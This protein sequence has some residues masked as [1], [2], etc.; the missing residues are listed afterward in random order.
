MNP[1]PQV[2]T[3]PPDERVVSD[4]VSEVYG[5]RGGQQ[6]WG[7]VLVSSSPWDL[8]SYKGVLVSPNVTMALAAG[9][10]AVVF[11]ARAAPVDC[12]HP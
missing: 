12:A 1:F 5:G 6:G 9:L 11:D 7:G 2:R 10:G 3:L 8:Q 4:P